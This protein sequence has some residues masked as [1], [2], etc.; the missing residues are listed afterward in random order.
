M[1]SA[2]DVCKHRNRGM[3]DRRE[4]MPGRHPVNARH[5]QD[6]A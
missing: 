1:T 3:H 4:G 6:A 2:K 5:P